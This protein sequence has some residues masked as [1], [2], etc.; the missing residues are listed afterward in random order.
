MQAALATGT[1][2]GFVWWIPG[3]L[4]L[5]PAFMGM[6]FGVNWNLEAITQA[7]PSLIGHVVFGLALAFSYRWFE[8]RHTWPHTA[9][10]PSAE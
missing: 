9:H 5:M 3:P 4:T 7:V 2:Y 1:A 8:Q 10:H 6:G